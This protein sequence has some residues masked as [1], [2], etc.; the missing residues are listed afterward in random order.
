MNAISKALSSKHEAV[1]ISHNP[2]DKMWI[3]IEFDPSASG[4]S[5]ELWVNNDFAEGIVASTVS[6]AKK[7]LQE[8]ALKAFAIEPAMVYRKLA[9]NQAY[10]DM[11]PYRLEKNRYN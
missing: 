10:I 9:K 8:L 11:V 6:G 4:L 5:I 3:S 1:I 2:A 7:A